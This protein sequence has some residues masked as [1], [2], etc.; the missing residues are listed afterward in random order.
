MP[1]CSRLV[2]P[3]ALLFVG[4][5]VARAQGTTPDYRMLD[6]AKTSTMQKELQD[7]ADGGYRLV[8][9]QGSWLLSAILEKAAVE[10]APIDYLLLA[11]SKSGTMQK[12]MNE[13]AAKG[14]HF[15]SVLGIGPEVVICMERRRSVTTRTHEQKLLATTKI[16]TME[17]ELL[18][19][20]AKGF[21]FVGQ[22]VFEG[23]LGP[24]YV[25]IVERP[26]P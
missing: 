15:A 18:A 7:V 10:P 23:W 14:Y 16:G 24:E 22:T 6:T 17:H 11:T 13:A 9:G 21:R 19:E 3:A 20:A 12:E 1:T 4:A 2:L 26:V 25:A 8:P 5:G